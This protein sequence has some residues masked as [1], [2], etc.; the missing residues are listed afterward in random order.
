MSEN[1][2]WDEFVPENKSR[3]VTFKAP[4]DTFSGRIIDLR[5]VEDH[6]DPTKR[7]PELTFDEDGEKRVLTANTY[8]LKV[9]IA[10]LRPKVGDDLGVRLTEIRPLDNDKSMKVFDVRIRRASEREEQVKPVQL[11]QQTAADLPPQMRVSDF[12]S[13]ASQSESRPGSTPALPDDW[14]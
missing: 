10:Q 14:R 8:D 2:D 6:F 3:F 9:K 5:A 13:S 12:S 7:V 1:I 11:K 4:G